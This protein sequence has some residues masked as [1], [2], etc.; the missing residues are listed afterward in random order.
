ML[1]SIVYLTR[2]DISSNAAQAKQIISMSR[3][4]SKILGSKFLLVSSGEIPSTSESF[5]HK[6]LF[7]EEVKSVRY[8]ILC[9]E[10]AF[11]AVK[12]KYSTLYT[13]DILAAYVFNLFKKEAIYEAHKEPKSWVAKILMKRLALSKRFRIVAISNALANYY[14]NHYS[15][16]HK[17]LLVAHDGVFPE[18]YAP[19]LKVDKSELRKKLDLPDDMIVV[20]HT[21]SLYKGGAELYEGVLTATEDSVLFVHVGGSSRECQTWQNFYRNKCLENIRFISNQTSERVREYQVAADVLFYVTTKESPIYW[22]TSPLKL[23]EYM[24][25]ETPML[26]SN[27]GSLKEV[28]NHKNSFCYDPTSLLSVKEAFKACIRNPKE[29]VNRASVAKKLVLDCYSWHHRA[30][31]IL[32]F[33]LE[34][35][36]E[37]K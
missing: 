23:F 21:G 29:A 35:R 31:N 15:M 4:F 7:F 12:G 36:K 18:D 24:A 6:K 9:I 11:Y 1:E 27:I 20:I 26:V 10:A 25:S 5:C 32:G 30:K 17:Q 16:P 37:L 14:I 13:R 22:C 3:A 2:V 19:L 28:V 33:L 34:A 8:L